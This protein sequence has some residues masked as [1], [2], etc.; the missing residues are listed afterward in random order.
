MFTNETIFCLGFLSKFVVWKMVKKKNHDLIMVGTG[1]LTTLGFI[2]G[3]H[4]FS[5]CMTFSII[6][7]IKLLFVFHRENEQ[8]GL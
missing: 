4:Y 3:L 1:R 5:S 2:T 8:C 6:K 7:K